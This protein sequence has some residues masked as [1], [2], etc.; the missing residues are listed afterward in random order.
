MEVAGELRGRVLDDEAGRAEASCDAPAE[1]G[2]G[3]GAQS[4]PVGRPGVQ[5][6]LLESTEAQVLGVEPVQEVDG[7]KHIAAV[8]FVCGVGV[9]AS[10]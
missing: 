4:W 9:T 6:C 1:E 10:G 5:M 2:D 7:G 3:T 8:A